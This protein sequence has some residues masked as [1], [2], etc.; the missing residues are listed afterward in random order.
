MLSKKGIKIENSYKSI[1]NGA[2]GS[3]IA[4]IIIFFIPSLRDYAISFF[5]FFWSGLVWCWKALFVSYSLPGW[6]LLIISLLALFA[7]MCIFLIIKENKSPEFKAYTE[8]LLFNVKWRWNWSQNKIDNLW[9]YCP[10]C[11]AT[12]VYD[13]RTCRSF[14]SDIKKTDFICENCNSKVVSSVN[15]GDKNYVIGAAKRE[16]DRRIRTGEY[17]QINKP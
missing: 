6:L 1:R 2:I 3:T 4:G 11:D 10:S 12:L 15:G 13:D 17:K 16:I 7:I 8:D 14:Y 5:F 9:C